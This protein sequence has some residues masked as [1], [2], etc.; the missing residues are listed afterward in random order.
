MHIDSYFTEK[1]HI[2]S[3]AK[4][5]SMKTDYFHPYAVT[6]RAKGSAHIKAGP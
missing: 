5:E 2:H 1:K 4:K 6:V 3:Y